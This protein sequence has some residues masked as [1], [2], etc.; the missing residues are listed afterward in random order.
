MNEQSV[1]Y[2]HLAL[3]TRQRYIAD[4]YQFRP[5][6]KYHW[7]QRL[8]IWT[9][10]KLK[11]HAIFMEEQ[12]VR[13]ETIHK[14]NLEKQIVEQYQ[15]TLA[16]YHYSEADRLLVGPKEFDELMR[17]PLDRPFSINLNYGWVEPEL[18]EFTWHT[19]RTRHGLKVTVIPHMKGVLM[20]PE[21]WDK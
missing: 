19:R 20:L 6:R 18:R 5:D 11:C 8:A 16:W 17:L 13:K 9:L 12:M 7:L 14:A 4:R 1:E 21:G 10:R 15:D 3:E 2:V